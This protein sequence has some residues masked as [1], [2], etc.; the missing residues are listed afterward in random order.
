MN[1][2]L[3]LLFFSLC[4]TFI[5]ACSNEPGARQAKFY[6]FGTEINVSLYG[7]SEEAANN[8]VDAF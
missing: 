2:F 5:A 1:T 8:T 4:L 7:V 3:R 6:A